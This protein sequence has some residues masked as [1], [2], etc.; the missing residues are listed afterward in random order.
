[1]T[2]QIFSYLNM[3][4]QPIFGALQLLGLGIFVSAVF[5]FPLWIVVL[6]VGV[7]VGIYSVSGGRWA[8]M[9]T[10]FLQSL[11][12]YPVII[13]VTIL[14]F[15]KLGGVG[16]FWEQAGQVG[17]LD[18]TKETGAFRDNMYSFKWVIAIFVM[19]FVAQLQLG[20]AS[21][22]LS[23]K[24]GAEAKKAA[25]FMTLIGIMG[26]AFFVVPSFTA[27]I[28]YADQVAAYAGLIAKPAEAAFVV[29]CKNLLP[30]GL[31]GLVIVAM[32][33]ATASSMDTGLNNNSGVI[34]RNVVPPIRRIMKKP[35]L[36]G[37]QEL[38]LARWVSI[39]LCVLI[40]GLALY[41][42]VASDKGLFELMLAFA[43]RV[44]F[45]IS[46]PLLLALVLKNAPRSSVLFSIGV[47]LIVPWL[48]QP[49]VENFV[50]SPLDFADRLI[51][52][53]LCSMGG[54]A[55][56]YC[57]RR[58]ETQA[59][60]NLVAEFNRKMRTPVVF[61]EEVGE[62]NDGDQLVTIGKLT[63]YLALGF[64][65][66]LLVP[67]DVTGRLL[68]VAM[69]GIVGLVGAALLFAAHRLKKKASGQTPR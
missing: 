44:Q 61:A 2:Q 57:F 22:F 3:M 5:G 6:A 35:A 31:M 63:L 45:P 59:E 50:G 30:A 65:L 68:V 41:F 21:R 38:Q 42:S 4:M 27:R 28:L 48:A 64:F 69:S 11:T 54:F 26:I 33:S 40:I 29:A 47:G 9:A 15:F 12:M 67:N 58:F 37:Q 23:A 53:G 19:Q 51:L 10:D 32:F 25:L 34:V 39:I 43:A 49:V 14:C 66:L 16:Q 20:W 7:V 60:R 62:S 36:D 55:F 24:D 8:V 56:S 46:L 18:L 52:V 17:L 1:V 13:L